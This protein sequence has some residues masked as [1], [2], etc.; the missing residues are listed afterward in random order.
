MG[1]GSPGSPRPRV[2]PPLARIGDCRDRRLRRLCPPV[3]DQAPSAACTAHAIRRALESIQIKQAIADAFV[4]PACIYYNERVIEGPSMR[5]PVMIRDASRASR[6]RAAGT[7]SSA[8]LTK[9]FGASRGSAY[10]D[11]RSPPVQYERVTR[12][13]RAAR[14]LAAGYPGSSIL[15]LCELRDDCRRGVRAC[16]DAEPTSACRRTPCWRS[17]TTTRRTLHRPQFGQR[18]GHDGYFTMPTRI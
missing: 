16:A 14:C 13:W 4:R 9:Q 12:S 1:S 3:W 2:P 11:G 5:M 17:D 10:A 7:S 15:R 18:R 6:I 8:V